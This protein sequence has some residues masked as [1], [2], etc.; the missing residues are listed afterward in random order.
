MTKNF[1]KKL[2]VKPFKLSVGN[3]LI[4]SSESKLYQQISVFN[5]QKKKF[6]KKVKIV[7]LE[8][9]PFGAIPH[10]QYDLIIVLSIGNLKKITNYCLNRPEIVLT[11]NQ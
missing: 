4:S 7:K 11:S 9:K 6:E 10:C 1:V 2:A 3:P 8:V 5:C